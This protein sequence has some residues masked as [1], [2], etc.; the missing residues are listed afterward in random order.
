MKN[1]TETLHYFSKIN[2]Y[3]LRNSC[4]K[5]N[6][7]D[8]YVYDKYVI[9]NSEK[10]VLHLADKLIEFS[11]L[12]YALAYCILLESNNHYLA[13]KLELLDMKLHGIDTELLIYKSI[14]KNKKING[15]QLVKLQE[16]SKNRYETKTELAEIISHVIAIH[17][18]MEYSFNKDK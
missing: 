11:C 4:V 17:K 3:I 15:I 14:L 5:F 7:T 10:T 12:K 6:E 1:I 2:Q 16:N 8:Y 9:K 13:N 18:T